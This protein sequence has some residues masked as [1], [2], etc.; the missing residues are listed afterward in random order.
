MKLNFWQWIGIGLLVLGA[1][2]LFNRKDTDERKPGLP[3]T[4]Q[5]AP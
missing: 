3:N 5:P 4:V 2:L 1:V